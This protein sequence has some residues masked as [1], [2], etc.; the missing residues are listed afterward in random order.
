MVNVGEHS[1]AL[2]NAGGAVLCNQG[3]GARTEP[4]LGR[5]CRDDT[6]DGG[7]LCYAIG[8]FEVANTRGL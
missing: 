8:E 7:R 5:F 2:A 6:D 1:V 3:L 4:V